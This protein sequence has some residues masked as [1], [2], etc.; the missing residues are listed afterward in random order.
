M[1]NAIYTNQAKKLENKDIQRKRIE[2]K[3]KEWSIPELGGG[4]QNWFSLLKELVGLVDDGKATDLDEK[5]VLNSISETYS[6]RVF[7]PFLKG[8]GLVNN[9]AGVLRLSSEGKKFCDSPDKRQLAILLHDRFRLFGEVLEML[10]ESPLTIEEAD[11]KICE[12]YGLDWSN[13]S[14]TRKRMDWLEMLDLIQ[15]VGNR[16]WEATVSGKEFLKNCI[17]VTP[18]ILKDMENDLGDIEIAEPPAEI[19]MLL[20]KLVDNPELHKK[21]STY[22]IW[23]PSPNRINN[24]RI[25]TQVA[26]ERIERNELFSFIKKEFNLKTSSAESMLPF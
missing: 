4:K 2:W 1:K 26:S 13:L 9:Q 21:R 12:V 6:W 17:L 19:A 23:T 16:K 8:I 25:I 5:L 3:R 10:V 11:K 7:L 15:G 20:Q 14:N 22:N 18:D 24:L